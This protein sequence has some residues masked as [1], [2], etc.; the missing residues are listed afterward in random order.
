MNIDPSPDEPSNIR[1]EYMTYSEVKRFFR[2]IFAI[3]S[4]L[5]VILASFGIVIAA[6]YA[7]NAINKD[8]TQDIECKYV[9]YSEETVI[10]EFTSTIIPDKKKFKLYCYCLDMLI[11]KPTEIS[12]LK[13]TSKT[14]QKL[15]PCKT[16]LTLYL[17]SKSLK[18]GI[19]VMIPVINIFLSSIMDC[20]IILLSFNGIREK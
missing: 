8:L 6:K 16:W 14:G 10:E 4:A 3:I 19:I 5:I 1:W 17:Q 18:I 2:R 20:K 7:E 12:T 9:K 11:T 13:L 15:E